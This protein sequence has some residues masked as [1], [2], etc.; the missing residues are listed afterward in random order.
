MPSEKTCKKRT[1]D[2]VVSADTTSDRPTN[3]KLPLQKSTFLRYHL[4]M[5]RSLYTDVDDS[6]YF[7]DGAVSEEVWD[8]I[9]RFLEQ[10]YELLQ[11]KNQADQWRSVV[12]ESNDYCR[13]NQTLQQP[14]STTSRTPTKYQ[15]TS[16]IKKRILSSPFGPETPIATTS[17]SG[18]NT[19]N[20]AFLLVSKLLDRRA[21]VA[22]NKARKMVHPFHEL[23]TA[24]CNRSKR[25][26]SLVESANEANKYDNSQGDNDNQQS[27]LY[28]I[29]AKNRLWKKLAN[30]LYNVIQI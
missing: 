26:D 11:I 25:L 20:N 4:K 27:I 12:I 14:S 21:R 28:E 3:H 2:E 29:D 19:S 23:Y 17:I 6:T 24:V 22:E 9:Q 5:L 8:M 16:P 18:K 30:D 15:H 1:I 7:N 10:R 13:Q